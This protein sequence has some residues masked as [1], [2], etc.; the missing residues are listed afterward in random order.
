MFTDIRQFY[1][2]SQFCN[3]YLF[4]HMTC[5]TIKGCPLV[6]VEFISFNNCIENILYLDYCNRLLLQENYLTAS[7]I[8]SN[9]NT[10]SIKFQTKHKKQMNDIGT[11][12]LPCCQL[13]IAEKLLSDNI[14]S[15]TQ[16]RGEGVV[17]V[18]GGMGQR[19]D[20]RRREVKI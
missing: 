12:I 10:N 3:I 7:K 8:Q 13:D 5:K 18:V 9:Y 17:D 6:N 11:H 16:R 2:C 19:R 4:F 14:V 1:I 15:V 20:G